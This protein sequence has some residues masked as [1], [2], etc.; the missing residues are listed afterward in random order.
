[1]RLASQKAPSAIRCIKTTQKRTLSAHSN[2]GQK[3]P[4]AIR[5][6]KTHVQTGFAVS[7]WV[8]QKAPSAIRC[9]KTNVT[10]L[11]SESVKP[12]VRKHLAP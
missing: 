10:L 7:L 1:M 5:C 6:I 3:A 9:I 8:S 2:D 11:P 4:S 12:L